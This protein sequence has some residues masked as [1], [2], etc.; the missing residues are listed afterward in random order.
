MRRK[1]EYQW[2]SWW[3]SLSN[4]KILKQGQQGI[5]AKPYVAAL[6]YIGVGL[7][8]I[9]LVLTRSAIPAYAQIQ[10]LHQQQLQ[11]EAAL[12]RIQQF[13]VSHADYDAY[14]AG[15]QRQLAQLRSKLPVLADVNQTQA[16]LQQLATRQNLMV[17]QLQLVEG[18]QE[19]FQQKQ[20]GKAKQQLLSSKMLQMELVGDYFGLVRWLKQVEKQHVQVQRVELKGN[21]MGMVQAELSLRCFFWHNAAGQKD[22]ELLN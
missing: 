3:G 15:K 19:S 6:L 9:A 18:K 17:K 7:G 5:N 20:A 13:A 16:K 1:N 12:Q 21:N 10:A 22:Y 14:I 8:A 2:K 11:K 4:L